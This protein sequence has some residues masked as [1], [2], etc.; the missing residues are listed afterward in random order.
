M[1]YSLPLPQTIGTNFGVKSDGVLL[2]TVSHETFNGQAY[3]SYA[4]Q[5]TYGIQSNFNNSTSQYIWTPYEDQ[6]NAGT[7]VSPF[8]PVS[9][10]NPN[11]EFYL[12]VKTGI[13]SFKFNVTTAGVGTFVFQVQ[14]L[15][16]TGYIA[17]PGAT[18]SSNFFKQ[19]GI[20]TLTFTPPT[21][22]QSGFIGYP[23]PSEKWLKI[24]VVSG[25]TFST[26]PVV[27]GAWEVSTTISA[28]GAATAN[29]PFSNP[30]K[31]L[32]PQ[33]GDTLYMSSQYQPYGMAISYT[34]PLSAGHVTYNYSKVDGTFAP[35]TVIS[36]TS[37]GFTV[38]NSQTWDKLTLT[39]TSTSAVAYS[40][41]AIEGN[42]CLRATVTGVVTN[43]ANRF[44]L[45]LTVDQAT[46]GYGL[47]LNPATNT[48]YQ[49]TVN[50]TAIFT[51]TV[52]I[53][54]NDIIEVWRIDGKLYFFVNGVNINP[55]GTPPVYEGL[56]YARVQALNTSTVIPVTLIDW[57]ARK[58]VPLAI[59]P[60]NVTNFTS[61]TASTTQNFPETFYIQFVPPTDFASLTTSLSK[62][63]V[64][65]YNIGIV[66]DF[67]SGSATHNVTLLIENAL[68]VNSPSNVF[69]NT[70]EQT[71]LQRTNL[72][73]YDNDVTFDAQKF[74]FILNNNVGQATRLITM[75]PTDTTQSILT[76]A[77]TKIGMTGIIIVQVDG[78]DEITIGSPS[79]FTINT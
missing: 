43:L 70:G 14:Y 65:G 22:W 64:A 63:G 3:F 33:T 76:S 15:S 77:V 18:L 37:T 2:G 27:T 55:T 52:L 16:P 72:V 39:S 57:S 6:F 40:T 74:L 48:H 21:D 67:T 54:Q 78:D 46:L 4:H 50:G 62:T 73:M 53:A 56:L 44:T 20:S 8:N 12:A 24:V 51:S 45:A 5:I 49:I 71:I 61:G 75:G 58:A 38:A 66:S 30:Y 79:Y 69:L 26:Q 41:E 19:T 68:T 32:L 31:S 10:G 47:S 29:P 60:M 34:D 23:T 28:A 36:D 9:V 42:G 59:T 13:T 17:L 11:P 25:G 1:D 7:A 35:L